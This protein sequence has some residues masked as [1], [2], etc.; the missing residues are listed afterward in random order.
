MPTSKEIVGNQP[1][2][3][4]ELA[5]II[6]NDVNAVLSHD[7]LLGSNHIAFHRV[8]YEVLV[9]LHLDNPAYPEH[10]TVVRP[11]GKRPNV[12]GPPPLKNPSEEAFVSSIERHRDIISPNAARVDQGLPVSIMSKE[13]DG[14][15]IERRMVYPED[16]IPEGTMP[17]PS[18]IDLTRIT[19]ESWK[20]DKK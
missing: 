17:E 2:N 8:S 20:E 16:A 1:L 10:K 4:Q 6:L 5:H 19:K 18:D 12:E 7:G 11:Q 9:T 13:H 3:G 14:T 15:V